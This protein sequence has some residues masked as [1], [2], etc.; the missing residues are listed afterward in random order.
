MGRR[1][2]FRSAALLLPLQ[3]IAAGRT[4][5]AAQERDLYAALPVEGAQPAA[6]KTHD[7]DDQRRAR[8]LYASG[9][10]AFQRGSFDE[11][12]AY[13]ERA[14]DLTSSPNIKLMLGRCLRQVDRP[15]DAYRTLLASVRESERAEPLRYAKTRTAALAELE[16]IRSRIGLLTVY[17]HAGRGP[18]YL[19]VAGQPISRDQWHTALPVEP[20]AVRLSLETLPGLIEHRE[21]EIVA[22]QTASITIGTPTADSPGEVSDVS[23]PRA[24]SELAPPRATHAATTTPAEGADTA[25]ALRTASYVLGGTGVVGLAAFAV[26]GTLSTAAWNELDAKCPIKTRCDAGLEPVA[27]RGQTLQT[28]AN[29]ALAAGSAALAIGLGLF[30]FSATEETAPRG[31]SVAVTPLDVQLRGNF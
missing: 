14:D 28:G 2:A 3:L 9:V 20:G 12:L 5:V 1:L 4:E 30:V 23:E 8:E 26:F 19:H 27:K 10:A 6:A 22:G 13:F 21:I 11:A 15:A 7:P 16:L 31:V 25:S 17:V 29:I 18:A 24:P